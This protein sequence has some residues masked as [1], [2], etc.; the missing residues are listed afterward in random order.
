MISLQIPL[1]L[2]PS[3]DSAHA[4]EQC[5]E[6]STL[7]QELGTA[8]SLSQ[9]STPQERMH[10]KWSCVLP[11]PGLSNSFHCPAYALSSLAFSSSVDVDGK[12]LALYVN[13]T[14]SVS[15]RPAS[16]A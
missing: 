15:H 10:L 8:E 16:L 6:Q 13:R 7:R 9:C 4:L 1:I 14:G 3:A 5:L 2:I 12:Y 11:G